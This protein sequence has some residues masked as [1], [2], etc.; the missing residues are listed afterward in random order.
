[1]RNL[2]ILA[3]VVVVCL[4]AAVAIVQAANPVTWVIDDLTTTGGDVFWT[5]PTFVDPIHTSYNYTYNITKVEAKSLFIWVDVTGSLDPNSLIGSGTE[6]GPCPIEMYNEAFS[7][8]GV[9][10]ATVHAYADSS[11]YGHMNMTGIS[12]GSY[13]GLPISGLRISASIEVEGNTPPEPPA[14][15]YI[16]QETAPGTWDVSVE[17]TGDETSGLSAYEIWVDVDPSTVN[18]TENTLGTVVGINYDPIGFLSGNLLQGDVGGNFNAGNF[19]GSGDGALQGIG[20]VAIDE[21]GS[22]PGTTPHVDLDVPALLGT[23][24][25]PTGLTEEDFRVL[26]AGLL[27]AAGDGFVDTGSLIPTMEVI[28]LAFLMG[29]AN[30]DGVV[31]AGDYATVQANFGNVG[32]GILGDANG[33]GVVSAGDYATVQANFGNVAAAVTPTPEPATIC[34]LGI[35]VFGLV[36]RRRKSA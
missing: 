16:F 14:V 10:D 17:V 26:T 36:N 8:P 4:L 31:S 27:N 15:N 23:L 11:G 13:G 34:M 32:I 1:M 5:S 3:L 29:D 12:F 19:Q 22:L 28:P 7:E 30:H 6:P 21:P 35:G 18:Y 20:M 33:D 9:L 2:S 24:S 25:A